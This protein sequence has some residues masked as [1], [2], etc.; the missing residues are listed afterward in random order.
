MRGTIPR[1]VIRTTPHSPWQGAFLAALPHG[2]AAGV[3]LPPTSDPVPENVLARLHPEERAVAVT[4]AGFRQTQFV[5]GRL[6]IAA[7]A[8][9]LGMRRTPTL[10]NEHGAPVIGANTSVSIS[11]K[12]DLAV[13]LVARGAARLGIDIEETDRDRPGVARRVL[14]ADEFAAVEALPESRRWTDTVIRF[15]VK[16]AIYKALHPF[17]HRYI[18]FGEVEVWPTPDGNDVVKP[19]MEEGAA[20]VFEARHFWVEHRVLATVRV[21]PA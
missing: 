6:A 9:D 11:H 15:S 8:A 12:Q 7:I 16:E 10:P 3:H 18:G 1:V 13:A 20:Y 14:T 4:L 2:L 19:L 21:R 5:G 17:L